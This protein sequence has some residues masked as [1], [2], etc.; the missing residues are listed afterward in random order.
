MPIIGAFVVGLLF[1]LLTAWSVRWIMA[2]GLIPALIFWL[3]LS[4]GVVTSPEG[5]G[6]DLTE[7][8]YVVMWGTVS[9]FLWVCWSLGVVHAQASCCVGKCGVQ[10]GAGGRGCRGTGSCLHDLR[11]IAITNDAASGANAIAVMTKAGHSDMKTTKRYM[12]LA[13][14]V[15]STIPHIRPPSTTSPRRDARSTR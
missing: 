13:G 3:S 8:G 9:V 6:G 12:H 7:T 10:S 5:G 2:I 14:V 1:T 15:S 4:Y 11:H